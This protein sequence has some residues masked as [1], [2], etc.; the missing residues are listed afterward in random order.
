MI[1]AY[2]GRQIHLSMT[3]K[4]SASIKFLL[5]SQGEDDIFNEMDITPVGMNNGIEVEWKAL[6]KL[7]WYPWDKFY[8][9]F[10][11]RMTGNNYEDALN[12]LKDFIEG[13]K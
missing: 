3:S 6:T 8:G 12:H 10:V 1:L 5:Q 9:I 11:D 4:D 2:K 7:H 13:N